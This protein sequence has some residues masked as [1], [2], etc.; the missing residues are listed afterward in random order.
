MPGFASLIECAKNTFTH[1][2]HV[3]SHKILQLVVTSNNTL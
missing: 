1:V 3:N 2:I